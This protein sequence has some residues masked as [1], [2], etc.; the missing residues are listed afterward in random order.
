[1][2][3]VLYDY[4][5]QTRPNVLFGGADSIGFDATKVNNDGNYT[6]VQSRTQLSA[7]DTSNEPYVAGLF[8]NGQMPYE[9]DYDQGTDNGYNTLPHLSEMTN[10]A[11]DLLDN[12]PDGFFLMVEGG[13]ID[14][15]GHNT[16]NSNLTRKTGRNI[17]ETLEF[18]NAIQE[19]L[20]W[21]SLNDPGLANT[22]IIVT[23]DHETGG[24]LVTETNPMAGTLPAVVWGGASHTGVDVPL[25]AIGVNSGLI[26]GV[27]D[28]TD[29]LAV[30][31]QTT[32]DGDFDEDS[33]V[34]GADFLAW[35]RD[36]SVGN[37]ADWEANFG[38]T[39]AVEATSSSVPEPGSMLLLLAGS[40]VLFFER[41]AR[42][43]RVLGVQTLS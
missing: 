2:L 33:D 13:R 23:A 9:Y 10:T 26:S 15:A 14:H 7:L 1:M 43:R 31:M 25:A 37:L 38:T 16:N 29:L 35:Q 20:D 18:T 17:F 27:M 42:I 21:V 5:N 3:S 12:D 8:G 39:S 34:D 19:V 24:L 40:A 32:L 28:N 6:L 11:L 30:V 36:T 41:R 4:F 22:L